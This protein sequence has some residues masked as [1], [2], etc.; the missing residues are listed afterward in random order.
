MTDSIAHASFSNATLAVSCVS[1]SSR[2]SGPSLNNEN[3][4]DSKSQ[5]YR[6]ENRGAPVG[7]TLS[8][9]TIDLA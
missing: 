6:G 1:L 9:Q 3:P 8:R 4:Y 5:G 2:M 7:G